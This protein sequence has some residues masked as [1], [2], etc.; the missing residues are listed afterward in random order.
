MAVP[1][2]Y[3]N[4][5]RNPAQDQ[6]GFICSPKDPNA[7]LPC[8]EMVELDDKIE[9]MRTAIVEMEIKRRELKMHVNS[10]HDRVT[11]DI[12]PEITAE[13]FQLCL[14]E[15]LPSANIAYKVK[16]LRTLGMP[17]ILSAVS[18]RWRQMALAS[19]RLWSNVAL[20][21]ME[22]N[23]HSLPI[24]TNEWLERSG[25]CPLSINIYIRASTTTT[26]TSIQGRELIKLACQYSSR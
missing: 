25:E 8:R 13:I 4:R 15:G 22:R 18:R 23:L 21:L 10:S 26:N 14:P 9:E 1:C 16:S 5:L 11:R 12:P 19:P 20:R 2:P 17:L 7:C 3:C 24:L 6:D